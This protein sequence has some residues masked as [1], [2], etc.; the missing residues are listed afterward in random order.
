MKMKLATV[1][2]CALLAVSPTGGGGQER[3][4]PPSRL[5]MTL[6]DAIALALQS[7]R[8]II[9]ARLN[10]A[11]QKLT[12][13]SAE[14]E[15]RPKANINSSMGPDWRKGGPA[16]SATITP[17]V[18][19]KIPTGGT[20]KV[21]WE[22]TVS[23][24][25]GTPYDTSLTFSFTQ[26]LLK[27]VGSAINTASLESARRMEKR[28][29]L[30]FRETVS[31]KIVEVIEA[32][33]DFVQA[34]QK[35]DIDARSLRRARE[36]LAVNQLLVQTGRMARRDIIQTEAQVAAQE[37]SLEGAR[38]EL[39]NQRQE[40]T[41]LLDIDSLTPIEATETLIIQ[42]RR[43]DIAQA[44]ELAVKNSTDY[45]E[46]LLSIEDAKSALLKAEDDLHWDLK[47]TSSVTFDEKGR[48]Y[49][50]ALSDAF[51]EADYGIGL[52][53]DIPLLKDRGQQIA[54]EIRLVKARTSLK[55][56][57][58]DLAEK[59]RSIARDVRNKSRAVENGFRQ[60]ELARRARELTEEKLEIE[61]EKMRL[62]LSSNFQLVRFEDDL[63][64]AQNAE[65]DAKISY[66]KAVT[67][68]DQTLGTTL[69][70]WRIDI[71]RMEG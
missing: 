13:E 24:S 63:V 44:T 3:P 9:K 53:L 43:I 5:E 21:D 65:V 70:T 35:L 28:N 69:D 41:N 40:L 27:G 67:A 15:F 39:G 2:L 56:A 31:A 8:D 23:D 26:P 71:K 46:A 52:K 66:F 17:E 11:V 12:L 19:L 57:R 7:N 10:R 54:E 22:N 29:I 61:R 25:S 45:L 34:G 6:A 55:N 18:K 37:R 20:F 51:D 38:I 48:S 49:D 59:R 42:P 36:Q 1:L 60:V 50:D 30:T 62:G 33:W 16:H 14:D 47:L 58:D 64:T 32:Y 4:A 68:L